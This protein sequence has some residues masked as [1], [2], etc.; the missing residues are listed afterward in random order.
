MSQDGEDIKWPEIEN[1]LDYRHLIDKLVP[2]E[3]IASS[4][5]EFIPSKNLRD[6]IR[7]KIN[8]AA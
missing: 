3:K 6:E 8:Y 4:G 2:K 1:Y 7:K 5:K